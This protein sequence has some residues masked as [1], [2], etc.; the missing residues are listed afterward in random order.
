MVMIINGDGDDYDIDHFDDE[1]DV[2]WNVC[3]DDGGGGDDDD[4]D[5]GND[6]VD[7]EESGGDDYDPHVVPWWWWVGGG[8]SEAMMWLRMQYLA[9]FT[10]LVE[11]CNAEKC[12]YL[13]YP[14]A[15]LNQCNASK[16][17]AII[18]KQ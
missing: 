9:I 15:R 18:T 4:S 5:V 16:G 6:D 2:G 1:E 11:Q 14:W 3:N 10:T 8:F 17:S 12:N 7:G 13:Y